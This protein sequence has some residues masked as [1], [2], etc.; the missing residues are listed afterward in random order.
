MGVGLWGGRFFLFFFLK[1]ILAY[2][3]SHG[4]PGWPVKGV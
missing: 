4:E 2:G 1:S 3:L